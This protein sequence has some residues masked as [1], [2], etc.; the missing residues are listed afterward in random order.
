MDIQA[1][2]V[3]AKNQTLNLFDEE[4][5]QT[6][7]SELFVKINSAVTQIIRELGVPAHVKG[8]CYLR[9]A[10]AMAT[11]NYEL[12]YAITKELYPAIA[13]KYNTTPQR[14]ER[15]IRHAVELA[16]DTGD[17]EALSQYFSYRIKKNFD[18]P[19]NSE[20]IAN[21]SDSVRIKLN[22]DQ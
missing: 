2:T 22:I 6:K 4:F 16:W 11:E 12:T 18:K 20:V 13:K 8:Y 9:S 1:K 15:D 19:T 10:I 3:S 17:M 7:S 5:S 14:V 21:I